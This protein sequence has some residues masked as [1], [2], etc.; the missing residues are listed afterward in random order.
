MPKRRNLKKPFYLIALFG[1]LSPAFWFGFSSLYIYEKINLYLSFN[2]KLN[3]NTY[4]GGFKEPNYDLLEKRAIQIEERIQ[5]YHTPNGSV[6]N[7]YYDNKDLTEAIYYSGLDDTTIWTGC[8]LGGEAFR[9]AVADRNNDIEN[10]TNAEQ[11]ILRA[12]KHFDICLQITGIKGALPRYAV[13]GTKENQNLGLWDEDD[14]EVK[15]G[16]YKGWRYRT[17]ISRDQLNGLGFGYGLVYQLVDNQTIRNYIKKHVSWIIDY[18]QSTRWESIMEDG[19]QSFRLAAMEP[20]LYRTFSGSEHLLAWINLGRMVNFEKYD[21][22]YRKWAID[23]N[24]IFMTDEYVRPN[25]LHAY[26][27]INV[28]TLAYY[29]LINSEPNPEYRKIYADSYIRSVYE[30]VKYHRNAFQNLIYLNITGMDRFNPNA[31]MILKDILDSLQRYAETKVPHIKVPILNSYYPDYEDIVDPISVE[32]EE[33]MQDPALALNPLMEHYEFE[34]HAKYALPVD[35]RGQ[36]SFIWQRS[37]FKLDSWGKNSKF[38]Y[39][40]V[41]FIL[42]YWMGRYLYLIPNGEGVYN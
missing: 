17:Y 13:E 27:S 42:P 19:T 26:Y 11:A 18:F 8:Y 10:R 41:D 6:L 15:E 25:I 7:V 4:I 40:G 24:L 5:K 21:P 16:A 28:V 14:S 39:A 33:K 31:N 34:A 1:I 20:M 2:D 29:T 23:K 36:D 3:Y 30:L 12:I 9:W 37:P 38:A 32:L 22:I 35:R